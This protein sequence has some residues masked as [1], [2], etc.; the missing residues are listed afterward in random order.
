M[1]LLAKIDCIH[2]RLHGDY[3]AM[4]HHWRAHPLSQFRY[5]KA[6]FIGAGALLVWLSRYPM[7]RRAYMLTNLVT[8]SSLN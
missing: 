5:K 3:N 6:L 7:V 8:K 4:Q 2:T 1:K